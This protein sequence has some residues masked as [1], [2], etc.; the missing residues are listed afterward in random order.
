MH[1]IL[2][3]VFDLWMCAKVSVFFGFLR[4]EPESNRNH[5]KINLFYA[6]LVSSKENASGIIN[7]IQLS[8]SA[9]HRKWEEIDCVEF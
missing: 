8:Y 9:R 6:V 5:G 3:F 1:P 2:P 7:M 4:K